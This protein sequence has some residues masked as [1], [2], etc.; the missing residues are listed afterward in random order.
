VLT[1]TRADY[2]ST[3]GL[4]YLFESYRRIIEEHANDI[5]VLGLGAQ[6]APA[7]PLHLGVLFTMIQFSRPDRPYARQAQAMASVRGDPYGYPTF[8]AMLRYNNANYDDAGDG[9]VPVSLLNNIDANVAADL[10]Q[11]ATEFLKRIV[12]N[13]GVRL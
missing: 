11:I 12:D 13:E 7:R 2:L 4:R 5:T 10:D 3:I 8:D 6:P 1:P 9:G